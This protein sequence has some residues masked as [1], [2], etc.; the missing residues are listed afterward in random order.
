MSSG[1]FSLSSR[2]SFF[3]GVSCLLAGA[4]SGGCGSSASP[5][6]PKGNVVLM[7]ANN[8]TADAKLTIPT[9]ETMPG[10]DLMICWDKIMKDLLCHPVV[11]STDIDDVGFAKIPLQPAQ[12]ED[13]LAVG[14]FDT[15]IVMPYMEHRVTSNETCT[16]LSTFVFGGPNLN[17]ANDYKEDSTK[18]YMLLFQT[19]TDPAVNVKSMTFI[20][21]TS[22]STN[23][24]VDA[25][26]T[27][28]GKVLDFSAMLGQAINIPK[29]GPWLVDWS[30]V[31]TDSFGNP[32]NFKHLD[33]VEVGFYQNKTAADIQT[34]FVNIEVNATSLYSVAVPQGSR[35]VDLKGAT[36]VS[37]PATAFPGFDRTDGVYL[38]AVLSSTSQTPAPVVLSILSPQ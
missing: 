33:K 12:I 11:P 5:E 22:T 36:D 4:V 20:K 24:K 35:D 21:P 16:M 30:Q 29:A 3:G 25:P 31:T 13:Q 37:N 7:D 38:V 19:G 28:S 1:S 10:A 32:I 8:Y 15:N 17:P 2:V 18:T 9:V 34:D 23:T 26:D 27:C 14:K 6:W